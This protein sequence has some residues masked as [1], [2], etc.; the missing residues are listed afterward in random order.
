MLAATGAQAK[1]IMKGPMVTGADRLHAHMGRESVKQP[2]AMVCSRE[3]AGR[4]QGGIFGQQRVMD[5][6]LLS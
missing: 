3:R 2:A 1:R 6:H 5:C 4:Q